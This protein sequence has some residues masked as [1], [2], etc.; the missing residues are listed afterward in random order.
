MAKRPTNEVAQ[1]IEKTRNHDAQRLVLIAEYQK[2]I[3]ANETLIA[4]MEPL[5][6]WEEDPEYP[7][8]M[9]A[10]QTAPPLP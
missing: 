2:Q 9:N 5:A 6:T 4:Q 1:F 8:Y 7:D 3:D 10:E